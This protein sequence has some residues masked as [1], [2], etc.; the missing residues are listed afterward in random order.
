MEKIT[1]IPRIQTKGILIKFLQLYQREWP[2]FRRKI[3]KTM[4]K[5]AK[6][7]QMF[8]KEVRLSRR[9][10]GDKICKIIL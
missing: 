6:T 3:A 10:P 9:V 5:M 2:V 1:P 7:D 4:R 8:L